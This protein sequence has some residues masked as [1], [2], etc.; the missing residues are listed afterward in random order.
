MPV[1]ATIAGAGANSFGSDAESVAY[2]DARGRAAWSALTEE[3][4]TPLLVRAADYLVNTYSGRWRGTAAT[5]EQAL[6]FPR[7]GLETPEGREIADD[8]MPEAVKRAQF[9]AALLLQEGVSLT[10]TVSG[11]AVRKTSVRAGSV[12]RETEYFT[13]DDG[14]TIVHVVE[15]LLR[16]YALIAGTSF[17]VTRVDR[18]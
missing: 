5:E 8:E 1:D 4:R 18:A 9:E 15:D 16:P 12:Q 14:R 7:T 6:P 13:A 10:R 17:S 11:G 2:H 3:Q